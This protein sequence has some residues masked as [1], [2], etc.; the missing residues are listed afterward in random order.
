M[1]LHI[2]ENEE[3]F[4]AK[5]LGIYMPPSLK[6][7][8]FIHCSTFEQSLEVANLF[9]EGNKNLLILCIDLDKL[10]SKYVYEDLIQSG[11]LYPH[12]YGPL[13][14]DAVIKVVEFPV[15]SNGTFTVLPEDIQ[16]LLSK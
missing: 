4:K 6:A 10:E 16:L 2:I 12:I 3:W 9:F 14:L 1:I 7:E 13:N 15:S 8:G 11:K 5:E